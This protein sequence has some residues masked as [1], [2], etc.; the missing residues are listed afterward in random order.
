MEGGENPSRQQNKKKRITIHSSLILL[1]S[2]KFAYKSSSKFFEF[3]ILTDD[4]VTLDDNV[5]WYNLYT[6]ILYKAINMQAYGSFVIIFINKM[7]YSIIISST[8]RSLSNLVSLSKFY[9]NLKK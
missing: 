8:F 4:S 3:A 6:Y 2:Y 9:C 5:L 1:H 7:F